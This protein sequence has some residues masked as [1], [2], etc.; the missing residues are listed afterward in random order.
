MCLNHELIS[1]LQVIYI[2]SAWMSQVIMHQYKLVT[3]SD[4]TDLLSDYNNALINMNSM[5]V[6]G[7]EWPS[8]S[9]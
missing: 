4:R 9:A 7:V 1:T 6:K 8:R 5:N 2:Q 3:A